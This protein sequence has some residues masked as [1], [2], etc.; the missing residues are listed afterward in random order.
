MDFIQNISIQMIQAVQSLSPVLDSL[1]KFFNSLG[2]PGFLLLL[3][4]LVYWTVSKKVGKMALFTLILTAFLGLVLTQ[5]LRQPRPYWL[6]EVL[7]LATETTYAN[8]SSQASASLAVLGYLAY[9]IN[10]E[11]LWAASGLSIVLI[12]FSRL[13]LGVQF[14]VDILCG[15]FLGLVVI[16]VLIKIEPISLAWWSKLSKAGQSGIIFAISILM[17]IAGVGIGRLIAHIPDPFFW[18]EYASKARSLIQY[19]SIG[20][21]YFGAACG[22]ILMKPYIG[23][24]SRCSFA[25]NVW[26]CA[27]GFVGLFAIYFSLDW[28]MELLIRSGTYLAYAISYMQLALVT[29]WILFVAPWFFKRLKLVK[30]NIAYPVA[31]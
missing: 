28:G 18:G 23:Y 16:F 5:L 11:W 27:F 15:W 31:T 19:F 4:S 20:G 8:P 9:R 22:W 21:A 1:S 3:A 29:F 30:P 14:P 10:K 6:G 17:I 2:T 25:T 26:K 24:E 13:Y 7:P 12:A